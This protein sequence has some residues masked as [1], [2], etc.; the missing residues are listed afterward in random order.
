MIAAGDLRVLSAA[1]ASGA[2][3]ELVV[4][5]CLYACCG[6]G[7]TERAGY[8]QTFHGTV[9]TLTDTGVRLH[10]EGIGTLNYVVLVELADV[11]EVRLVD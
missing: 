2:R 1:A 5:A 11:E 10:S 3:V 6:K 4:T 7:F 8:E 9:H